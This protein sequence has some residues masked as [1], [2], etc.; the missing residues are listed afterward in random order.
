[1]QAKKTFNCNDNTLEYFGA[2]PFW[3]FLYT[4]WP[5]V[6]KFEVFGKFIKLNLVVSL[7]W[8]FLLFL[9]PLVSES[10]GEFLTDHLNK[11]VPT[12]QEPCSSG[13]GRTLRF[14]RSWVQSKLE[15]HFFHLLWNLY[16][17]FEKTKINEKEAG[18]GQFF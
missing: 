14:Q 9:R 7:L 6:I 2:Y 1:M 12:G 11:K 5:D 13:Y 8:Q 16:C 3:A 18:V 4:V 10:L 15:W 17:V